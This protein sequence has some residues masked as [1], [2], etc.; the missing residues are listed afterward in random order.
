MIG[1]VVTLGHVQ[2]FGNGL[3]FRVPFASHLEKLSAKTQKLEEENTTPTKEG[4]SVKL[5]TAVLYRLDTTRAAQLYKE[6]GPDYVDV[7][8]KPEAASA[9]RG[10]TSE[11]EAKALYSSGRTQIQDQI[12]SELEHKLGP[13]GIIIEDVLLKD[14]QLPQELSKSI[15]L[16]VQAEQEAARMEFVLQKEKQE[17]QR[18]AIEAQGISDFQKIVSQGISPELLRWKGI[19]ATES[20]AGAPNTK[21]VI[22]GNGANG[23]PVILSASGT[24]E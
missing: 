2:A 6:V 8:L 12:Q 23:L 22:M 15:E 18:K 19:E 5:D 10:L 24:E 16:K 13:R 3:H 11:S 4:L 21:I 7:L 1:I 17:A 14:I 20:F 9:V